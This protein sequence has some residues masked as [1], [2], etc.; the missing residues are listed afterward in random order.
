MA[1][2]NNNVQ[3][4]LFLRNGGLYNDRAAATTGIIDNKDLVGDGQFIL[5]RY[6]ADDEIK[7]LVG[8]K[9]QGEQGSHL[10]II[11]VEGASEDVKELE[12]KILG[13]LGNGVSSANT[14]SNQLANLSGDTASTSADTSVEGAKRYA[15]DLVGTLEYTG[16]T[17]GDGVYITNVIEA[18]GVISATA[19]T[20]PTVTGEVESKKV[21]MSVSEDKGT[22]SVAK[23]T[24]ESA[25]K[26]VVISDLAEGNGID[27]KVNIDN[28]TLIADTGTGVISV[29]SA[30]LTQYVGDGKTIEIS[31]ADAQNNKTVS[32][33]LSISST[34][35]S[36]SNV[37]EQYNLVN[38]SGETIGAT[39]KIYKDSSLYR[40]YLGHV[41]DT[42]TSV[43]DPTVIPGS[44]DTALCFI[45]YTV[46]GEYE[47]VTVN[48]EE[49]I[50]ENEFASGVTW[51]STAKKVIG[52]VDPQSEVDSNGDA[53]L[54]V[55]AGGFK[56][57]GIKDE[58][59]AQLA[60]I[61][62]DLDADKSGSTEH[63][64]VRVEEVDGKITAVTVTEDNIA[65]ADDLAE[66]S[67][68]T[69]TDIDSA[70]GSITVTPTNAADGTQEIDLATDASKIKMTGFTTTTGS[71]L[72]AITTN[73]TVTEAFEEVDTVITAEI[74][75]AMDAEDE[76]EDKIEA[77][78]G[79]SLSGVSVNNVA[80]TKTNN[81]VNVQISGATSAATATNGE[82]IVVNTDQNTGAITLGLG[83]IDC[84]TY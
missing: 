23:G 69:I 27:F 79:A 51:D 8:V 5:A 28:D 43:D 73:S 16:V 38:A 6:H 42:I 53:F 21:V 14:V 49:F 25:D 55:G 3:G 44:G 58:I 63:V 9:Y 84:G 48:V 29:A 33:L 22:I 35:P 59:T 18:D 31:A 37:R 2:T 83:Y 70:N 1:K 4:V 75:R 57:D 32:T 15:D 10:T 20:L 76:L 78:S 56:V 46:N 77:L 60:E 41:D 66:L 13:I 62:A 72:T 71:S 61:V 54:T 34:T 19:A 7:T 65:D 52:V 45:Y 64:S 26:T 74:A 82:A 40:V 50:E 47:L 30:A 39:I 11:D 68:K 36:D 24:I 67:A 12:Q 81:A 80:L 17:T